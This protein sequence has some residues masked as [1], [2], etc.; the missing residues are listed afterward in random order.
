MTPNHEP[1]DQL[2]RQLADDAEALTPDYS[3]H[4]H[5]RTLRAIRVHQTRAAA[6]SRWSWNQ[7]IAAV[8][9]VLLLGLCTWYYAGGKLPVTPRLLATRMHTPEP[10]VGVD[11][12]IP[13]ATDLLRHGSAPLKDAI[14]GLDDAGLAQLGQN[15]RSLAQFLANQ[16][17][18]S[19]PRT[20]AP[21][22]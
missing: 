7:A 2:A 14:D 16:L 12:S 18:Q 1:Q 21:R 4:L 13:D 11:L 9:A 3:P 19:D 22:M 15:A 8:A 5:Q 6:Q 20:P 17:P 10:V